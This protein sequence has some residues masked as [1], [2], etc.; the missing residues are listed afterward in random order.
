MSKNPGRSDASAGFFPVFG[1]V[2]ACF[3]LLTSIQCSS[4]CLMRFGGE[5]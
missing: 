5:E 4:W 2:A 3:A 1:M